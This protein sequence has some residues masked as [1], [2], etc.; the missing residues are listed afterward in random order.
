MTRSPSILL[1]GVVLNFFIAVLFYGS[2]GM[3]SIAEDWIFP[4]AHY[5]L[6]YLSLLFLAIALPSFTFCVALEPGYLQKKYDFKLLVAELLEKDRDLLNL[7]SYCQLIK[8]P[9]SFHCQQCN[10]CVDLFDHHCPFLNN[11]LGLRNYKYF[12][13]FVTSYFLFLVT[14]LGELIRNQ[15]DIYKDRHADIVDENPWI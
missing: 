12:L 15:Y 9:T 10:R 13:T 1:Y 2:L 14:M 8:S 7:C 5:V 11:C 6:L 3:F 4:I